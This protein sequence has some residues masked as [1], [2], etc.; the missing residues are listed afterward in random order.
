MPH[1]YEVIRDR[2]VEQGA[3]LKEAKSRAAAIYNSR[4]KRG[5]A[6]VTGK[7]RP[8]YRVRGKKLEREG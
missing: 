5:E 3:P 8:K 2:L 6:P 4:R 7:H 1:K